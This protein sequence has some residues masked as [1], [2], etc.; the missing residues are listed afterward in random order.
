MGYTRANTAHLLQNYQ[1]VLS[2][3]SSSFGMGNINELG[4][5]LVN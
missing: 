3:Y 1:C 5:Y 4:F 2:F